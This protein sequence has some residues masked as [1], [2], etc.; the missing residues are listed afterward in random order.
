VN[1]NFGGRG[2]GLLPR[3]EEEDDDDPA[4]WV[5]NGKDSMVGGRGVWSPA[6]ISFALHI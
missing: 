4:G 6:A 3:E 1:R 5:V 2:G